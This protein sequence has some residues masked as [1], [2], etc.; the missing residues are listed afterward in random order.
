[1][2][3]TVVTVC[4]NAEKTIEDTILSVLKQTYDKI[5][6]LIIDGASED[7]TLDIAKKY[8]PD[9]RVSIV[10][11]KDFGLYYAMNKGINMAHGDYI[12]FMNSGDVFAD[13]RVIEDMISYMDRDIVYGDV[14]R[15]YIDRQKYE[16]SYSYPG[17]CLLLSIGRMM[18]HQSVFTR[19]D[20]LREQGFNESYH[21]CADYEFITRSV[22]EHRSFR[23]V[24]RV[25]AV[26][27]CVYGISQQLDNM[28]QMWAEDDRCLKH[29]LPILYYI[30]RIP[31]LV[32]RMVG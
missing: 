2:I 1:M 21:I 16:R 18:S 20:I 14:I 17:L 12:I 24:S 15:K 9:H 4:Y 5:E 25:V 28:D 7:R 32:K 30:T 19:A 27:D 29:Y 13:E 3:I 31:R 26:T 8:E 23:Y 10:S 11:E 6:Y 22:H